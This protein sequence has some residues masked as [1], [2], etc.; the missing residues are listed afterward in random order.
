MN[1]SFE[2]EFGLGKRRAV[3]LLLASLVASVPSAVVAQTPPPSPPPSAVLPPTRE[4]VTRP[5][6]QVPERLAPRL[7]VEGE[8]ERAPCALD[9]PD[10]QNIR[11]TV[12]GAQFE[13][14]QGLSPGD[15]APS[16]SQLMGTEQ[17]I[18]AVCQIRDHA[19]TILRD[20]GYIAAVEVPEQRI[21]DGI[22]RF[23]VLMARMTQVR[24]RGNASGAERTIA[25]YLNQLTKQPVFNRY[26]AERY[27]LLASD[28]PGYTVRLTLRPA[29]TAPGEVIGDVTVQRTPAY[30]DL[31]IQNG[32][33]RE[34]GRW[35]GLL[36]GQLF[37]LTGL[38]DRTT[39]SAFTT[40]DFKE[41]QTLQL[42]HDFRVGAE[43]LGVGGLLTYA[44]A[45]PSIQDDDSDIKARTLLATV[46]AD[47]PLIRSLARNLRGTVGMDIVNQD[48]EVDSIDLSRDRLRVA[49]ARFAFDA[50]STG[51]S[52]GRSLAEPEWRFNTEL[53]LRRGLNIFGAT[54]RCGPAGEG[55][56]GPG[57]V[58]PS[59]VEG[60]STAAVVRALLYGEYRP[61]PRLTVAL[62]AR[63][64]YAW[65]PLLSFEEFSAGNY[66]VGRGYNPGSLLGDRGWGTQAEIRVGSTVPTSARRPAIEGYVFW[67]HARVSNLDQL[68]VVDQPNHLNSVG[69][70]AR[71]AFDR[72]WLDAAVAVPLTRVG[73]PERKPDPRFLISLTTRLWPWSYR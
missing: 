68:F 29:G 9:S 20:A 24:V 58:S 31:N 53:E 26:D 71:A 41:Q 35:G 52:P 67:D 59:R 47:Y 23:R 46:Q 38:A 28:L 15:L 72:F 3:R 14:L 1:P 49:F 27:L 56:L 65:K 8:I 18:S 37:G 25:G 55:C 19:A 60:V 63:G 48:V 64:Q 36:R 4:E 16:Y 51:F 62:G 54:D 69:G 13:G 22:V 42:G 39:L 44:W 43:G 50:L 7:E 11:F 33:S 21:E 6:A 2:Q 40:S 30:A 73:F 45:N 32:G 57:Q 5:E 61:M 70:G 12:R 17:P 66:T 34:L 10:F